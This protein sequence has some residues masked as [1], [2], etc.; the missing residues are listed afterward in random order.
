MFTETEQVDL[1]AK[2]TAFVNEW[3]A[4]GNS[5]KAK[6]EIL[7]DYFVVFMVDESSA[8][9]SGCGID[10]S[11][12]FMKSQSKELQI[13]FFNRF[14]VVYLDGEKYEIANKDDFN[15]LIEEAVVNENTTVFNNLVQT[16]NELLNKWKLP[17][18]KTWLASF[19]TQN[20]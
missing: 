11:V 19:L 4:H 6:A 5:L 12:N 3:T 8:G 9:V 20:K 14:N 18:H 15:K 7:F 1:R 10:K 17:V 13:D 2:L 16:K